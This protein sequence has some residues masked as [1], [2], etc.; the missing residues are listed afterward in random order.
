[1]A[2]VI[3]IIIRTNAKYKKRV[4]KLL[5]VTC[6]YYIKNSTRHES[7]TSLYKNKLID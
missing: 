4:W 1:M 3:Q 6:V 5:H 7:K 2:Q